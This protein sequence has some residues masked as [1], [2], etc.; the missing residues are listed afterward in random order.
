MG[1]LLIKQSKFL[2]YVLRHKPEAI[3]LALDPEG[4]ALVDELIE[5]ADIK[6]DRDTIEVIVAE[7]DKKRFA[8]S[9]DGL[10][11]RAN[12]GH[13]ISVDLGLSA[14]K[15]PDIL[16]HGTAT[17]FLESIK[18]QGLLPQNRQHVH[19]SDNIET[20]TIVGARHGKPVILKINTLAMQQDGN[21]FYQSKNLVW[22]TDCV[23]PIYLKEV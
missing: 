9:E 14:I 12:Q 6:I 21:L 18:Q 5:K 22:L 3:N 4:W 16:Y 20:A 7:N 10:Y 13:S 19:L 23:Q 8:L 1:E 11:I 2:S 17:R 15:P